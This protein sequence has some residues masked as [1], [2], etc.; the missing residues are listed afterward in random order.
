MTRKPPPKKDASARPLPEQ[1]PLPVPPA[2][3]PGPD[4]NGRILFETMSQGVIFRDAAGRI[5]SANPAAER[6]FGRPLA[7]LLGKTSADV[8]GRALRDDG[9]PLSPG[10]FPGDIALRTGK[11]VRDFIMGTRNPA[12]GSQRWLSVNAMPIFSADKHLPALVYIIFDDITERREMDR[13]LRQARD[14]LEQEVQ[15]RTQELVDAN[16]ALSA[17]MAV[18]K[19]VEAALRES[20]ERYRRLAENAEDLIYVYRIRPER[21]FEYVSPSATRLTGFTP[22]EHYADPDLERKH[23]H[24][25]DRRIMDE[26]LAGRIEAGVPVTMRW[27][28]KDGGLLWVEQRNIPITADDGTVVAFQG[29]ARDITDRVRTEEKLREN[30]KFLQTVIES[31]PEC[32]KMIAR[33]GSLLMMNRAGLDMIDAGSLDQVKGQCI[34][35]LVDPAFRREFARLTEQV[36]EGKRGTLVFEA[37]GLKGRK[38]WLETTAVPLRDEKNAIIAALGITRDITERKEMESRLRRSEA[39]LR[40]AQRLAHLG[41]WERDPRTQTVSWSPETFR[42]LGRDPERDTP[43]FDA[44]VNAVHPRDRERVTAALA[45]ALRS[46]APYDIEFRIIRPDGFVRTVQSRAEITFDETGMPVRLIGTLQD[47]TERRREEELLLRIAEH[48]AAKTGDDYFRSVTEFISRELGTDMTFVVERLPDERTART[49]M[50]YAEGGFVDNFVYNIADTPCENVIGRT[51]CF[52]PGGVQGLFPKDAMLAARGIESY[53]GIPLSDSSGAP[54]GGLVTMGRG[55]MREADRERIVTLLQICS[56]RVAAELERRRAERTLLASEQ[57]YRL[58]LESITSYFYTVTVEQGRAVSTVHGPACE[59]VTGYKSAEFAATPDLWYRMVHDDDRAAVLAQAADAVGGG[60]PGPIEHRIRHK[61]GRIVWIRNSVVPRFDDQ[62]KLTAY[63]G[64]IEDI[65]ERK[66]TEL[67]VRN[68]LE[69]VDEGFLVIDRDYTILSSNRAYLAQ[70]GLTHDEV[71]GRK[72]YDVSHRL[73]GPCHERGEC[74]SVQDALAGRETKISSHTHYDAAGGPIHVETRAYPLRNE[75]GEVIAAIEIA[76]NVTDRKQLED[77]LRHAQ[78]ME[79]IGF[80]AGGVAHD[81][82]NILTAI[83]GYGNLLKMKTAPEDPLRNYIEQILQSAGRAAGL[84][85][86]LLAFS[87]KQAINPAPMDLNDA[88]RRV[89]KL[90]E[91]VLGEDIELR[92]ETTPGPLN[93]MADSSQVEQILLNL[94]TNARDAMSRGGALTLQT[95]IAVIDD[96]FIQTQGFGVAGTYACVSVRDTGAG[97]DAETRRRI[98]EPFFTTKEVGKGSGLGLSIVYG[99]MKQNKGYITVDSEPGAGAI[100]RIYF[101]IIADAV[102]RSRPAEQTPPRAGHETILVAEDDPTLRELTR[103]MLTEFGYSV[104]EAAD[105]EDALQKFREHPDEVQLAI[106]DA[107]MPRMDGPRVRDE[108]MKLRPQVKVLF[109]SGY[110]GDML[111]EKGIAANGSDVM[112]KPVS[113]MDLLHAVRRL[114]DAAATGRR[115]GNDAGP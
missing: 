46:K 115:T 86:N 54:L 30:E 19:Q 70:L 48:I 84:T 37:T 100:F 61:S 80:F 34:Y 105:G 23:V 112:L 65:T 108:I 17:Q 109:L 68:I 59:A 75:A 1:S 5:V 63:D 98:F 11:P 26:L 35:T 4:E 45:D 102:E 20:E 42:I 22:A 110:T 76:H 43:S 16:E 72:C 114:L 95:S 85:R 29:M 91:R 53:A 67:L 93:I 97:M 7:E 47:L 13:A 103:T 89:E 28:R 82:N 73:S 90:L 38:V 94:A 88:I 3:R 39:N 113:P 77:Q 58:L 52:Y 87:R 27:Y 10:E 9:S 2:G 32:V 66:R 74:C 14:H 21:R 49:V 71:V 51:S 55:P 107:V 60:R 106:L 31:E 69:S 57:R 83:V 64:I 8:H 62:G 44:F 96:V 104:I 18:R 111:R 99:I 6:I 79:A 41:S 50:A 81:F 24:P 25:D 78:K 101:P 36:F 56:Y 12:D 33:D 40:E 92:I 15:E